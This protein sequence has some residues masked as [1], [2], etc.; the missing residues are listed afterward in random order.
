MV[1]GK[2]IFNVHWPKPGAN[3]GHLHGVLTTVGGFEP[4]TFRSEGDNTNHRATEVD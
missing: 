3:R 4:T 1:N 2:D